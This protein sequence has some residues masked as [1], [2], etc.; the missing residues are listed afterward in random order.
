MTLRATCPAIKVEVKLDPDRV[1]LTFK[2]RLNRR[3][4]PKAEEAVETVVVAPPT[5]PRPS[6]ENRW[7]AAADAVAAAYAEKIAPKLYHVVE[8]PGLVENDWR[9]MP[10]V[11]PERPTKRPYS[12]TARARS[13]HGMIKVAGFT[14]WPANRYAVVSERGQMM[15]QFNRAT[16][17]QGWADYLN[18]RVTA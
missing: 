1:K 8:L 9:G 13:P 16:E 5:K 4:Q 18:E 15:R 6:Y 7:F 3:R 17:A 10:Q 14:I 2:H 11:V 12:R